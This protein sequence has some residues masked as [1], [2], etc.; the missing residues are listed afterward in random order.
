VSGFLNV[1]AVGGNATKHVI[2]VAT[3]SGGLSGFSVSVTPNFGAIDVAASH[4][5]TID[6]IYSRST[7]DL[8]L[9]LQGG[10]AQSYVSSVT[11]ETG[12]GTVRTYQTSAAAIYQNQSGVLTVWAW[13]DGSSPVWTSSDDTEQHYVLIR[14]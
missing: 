13:G 10:F 14:Y 8:Q 9:W 6:G 11:I 1:L 2:T 12:A 7:S 3:S 4:G 5:V